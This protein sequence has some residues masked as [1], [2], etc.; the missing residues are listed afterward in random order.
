MG[1]PRKAAQVRTRSVLAWGTG[2]VAEVAGPS[3]PAACDLIGG[4]LGHLDEC[5]GGI[6]FEHQ[7]LGNGRPFEIK[8]QP[9]IGDVLGLVID[10]LHHPLGTA[11]HDGGPVFAVHPGTLD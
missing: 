3:E 9:L 8:G 4:A 1:D 11:H 7:H 6:G 10:D 5:G 2:G